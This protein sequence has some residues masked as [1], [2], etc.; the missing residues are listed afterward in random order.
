[1]K[2]YRYRVF[3]ERT[4]KIINSEEFFFGDWKDMNDPMEG[5][6]EYF[7]H[8]HTKNE[9][10][11]LKNSKNAYGICCFSKE[12]NNILLW[13]H[14]ADNH[15]GICI[16]I[17]VDDVLCKNQNISFEDIKYK[18]NIPKLVDSTNQQDRAKWLLSRKTILWNYEKEVRAFCKGS[19][20]LHKIG[21]ISKLFIGLRCPSNI[22]EELKLLCKDNNIVYQEVEIDFDNNLMVEKHNNTLER[23]I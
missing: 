10:T 4:K 12:Y 20:T 8:E 17:E 7:E 1:M 3:D 6:F 22:K 19:K 14:Y 18:S 13:S 21:K 23:N 9:I 15:K 5:F 11:E 2:I 16:E